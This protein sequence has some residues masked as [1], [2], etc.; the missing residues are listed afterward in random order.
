[1]WLARLTYCLLAT[2]PCAA[3]SQTP[4]EQAVAIDFVPVRPPDNFTVERIGPPM[5]S[6]WSLAF[7][8]GGRFLVSEKHG[9]LRLVSRDGAATPPIAGGPPNVV[10]K[11]DSGLLDVV[12]D[13]DFATNRTIYLAFVEGTEEANRTA[14]WKASLEGEALVGGRVMFRVAAAKN[15]ISHPGGRMLFLPDKTLLLTVGD[16]YDFKEKAQDPSSHL[17]KVLRLTRDGGVPADNPF[18]K[19]K[20]YLPEIWTMGHRNIQGLALD[21]ATGL[22]WSHEHGPRGGDELN[23][24]VAGRNYGWPV[25][26]HGIDYDG[27]II[28]AMAH[29]ADLAGSSFY[30]APSIAP[31]GLAVYHGV[32]FPDWEGKFLVGALA[33]RA[34]VQLRRGKD[35]GL[36]VEDGR[37]LLGLKERIRDVRVAPDGNLYLLTDGA[38][39]RLVRLLGTQSATLDPALDRL[40]FLRGRWRGESEIRPAFRPDAQAI[41]E[42]SEIDC[43]PAL[44]ATVLRC[45]SDFYRERDGRLRVV[46]LDYTKNPAKSGYDALVR[47]AGWSG[48]SQY[49]LGW[50]EAEQSWI[51]FQPTDHDGKPAMERIVDKPSVDGKTLVHTEA[52]RLDATPDAP[53][54]ETF[55]WTWTRMD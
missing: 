19:R 28:T 40:A 12:L 46:E 9:G 50:N 21:P 42:R 18:V 45:R 48:L 17:G 4:R 47:T 5:A 41:A 44:K 26:S 2:L 43:Q 37:W 54:T 3:W 33:S 30:W 32:V 7:L 53:W 16:G 52:I 25:V 23:Q 29:R 15:G 24:L 27:T 13:P 14:I 55:R 1:M 10:Q 31:S 35:T 20:G 36:M 8:P 49:V 6:P 34:L 51:A 38:S 22:V 39:G 11:S